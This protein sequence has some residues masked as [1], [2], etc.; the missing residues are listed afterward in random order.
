M[1]LRVD[2]STF[3]DGLAA[4]DFRVILI[5]APAGYGKTTLARMLAER[6]LVGSN[7]SRTVVVCSRVAL[8]NPTASSLAI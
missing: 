4:L 1:A 7:G 3:V 6:L 5:T 2:R 8:A